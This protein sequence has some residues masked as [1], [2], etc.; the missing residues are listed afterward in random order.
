[1]GGSFGTDFDRARQSIPGA[2]L[3]AYKIT[4]HKPFLFLDFSVI[5]GI[6]KW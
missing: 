4:Q 1:M 5:L 3:K 2:L 6:T